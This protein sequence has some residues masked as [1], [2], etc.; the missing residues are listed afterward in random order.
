MSRLFSRS[1]LLVLGI[2]LGL[3]AAAA[4]A[5][6]AG[7]PMGMRGPM[8][9]GMRAPMMTGMRGPMVSMNTAR[10]NM[11]GMMTPHVT[12]PRN[13]SVTIFPTPVTTPTVVPTV[14]P[15]VT[16]TFNSMTLAQRSAFL[17]QLYLARLLNGSLGMNPYSSLL[18]NGYGGMGGGYGS[19]GGSGS[20][21]GYGGGG[22]YGNGSGS[23]YQQPAAS[24]TDPYQTYAANYQSQDDGYSAVSAGYGNKSSQSK[25]V[26][27]MG[28]ILTAAGLPN[29]DGHLSW[30][31]GLRMLRP[32]GET[33][34]LRRQ[35]DTLVQALA[36]QRLSSQP[37]SAFV[38]DAEVALEKLRLLAERERHSLSYGTYR[39]V[40]RFLAMLDG[41]LKGV[42]QG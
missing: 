40:E 1:M 27:E 17:N 35:V 10:M 38:Q 20:G 32:D 23:G 31:L 19:G 11:P 3:I 8:M 39:E 9:M 24:T 14:M 12:T 30:P 2:P 37:N 16:P 41:F 7:R 25:R 18:G 34:D 4:V 22:G 13:P 6:A 21:G 29:K 5:N 42:D 26:S 28:T 36:T 33:R 15:M